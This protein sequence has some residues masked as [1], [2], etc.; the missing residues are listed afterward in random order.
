MYI[1]TTDTIEQHVEVTQQK[2]VAGRK[3]LQ[4]AKALQVTNIINNYSFTVCLLLLPV[5][6]QSSVV[7]LYH[8]YTSHCTSGIR[9]YCWHRYWSC[10]TLIHQHNFE[11]V[12]TVLLTPLKFIIIVA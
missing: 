1:F 5:A 10:K 7:L 6:K 9:S 2:T 11:F 12:I 3:K 4:Q 8:L